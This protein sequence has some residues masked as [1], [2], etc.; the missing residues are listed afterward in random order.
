[1]LYQPSPRAPGLSRQ[2][3]SVT[4]SQPSYSF[5]L[6]PATQ[7]QH[8]CSASA[9]LLTFDPAAQPRPSYSP[10]TQLLSLDPATQPQPS[11][12]ASAQ[13]L[14]LSPAA[15]PQ[16][17][18]LAAWPQPS[19]LASLVPSNASCHERP[20]KVSYT[21]HSN[22]RSMNTCISEYKLMY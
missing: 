18:Y 12:S 2:C 21:I 3:S 7:P 15:R 16:L 10:S 8:S 19:Y 9:Q 17:S 22:L 4:Q 14:S 20:L 5:S 11:C 1:M 6:V 13:L